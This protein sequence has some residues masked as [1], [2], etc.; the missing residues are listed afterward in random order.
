MRF[1]FSVQDTAFP[2]QQQQSGK[3]RQQLPY[4]VKM[5]SH[6]LV[7]EATHHGICSQ[8][9]QKGPGTLETLSQH[10]GSA[11]GLLMHQALRPVQYLVFF[12]GREEGSSR[13]RCRNASVWVFP[14]APT[15]I[16][17]VRGSIT[18]A[19]CS[20]TDLRISHRLPIRCR[21]FTGVRAKARVSSN[22]TAGTHRTMASTDSRST[23]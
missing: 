13:K 4:R 23:T 1:P 3:G 22:L 8:H 5:R 6:T 14:V 15:P 21:H 7:I 17:W 18:T 10:L 16:Q 12:Q 9:D 19:E 20:S 11:L 2:I